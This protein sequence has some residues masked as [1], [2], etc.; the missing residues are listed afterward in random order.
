MF[1]APPIS[2]RKIIGRFKF[3]GVLVKLRN[4]PNLIPRQYFWLYGTNN[5]IQV[6][7][8]ICVT[9]RSIY[10]AKKIVISFVN[11]RNTP[12]DMTIPA[13]LYLCRL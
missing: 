10:I 9:N 8:N 5:S 13:L 11:M 1:N 7:D 4:P 2:T 3:G 12:L 6:S